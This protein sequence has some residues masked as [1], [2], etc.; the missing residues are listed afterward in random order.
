[1]AGPGQIVAR[2]KGYL[3]SLGVMTNGQLMV[4]QTGGIPLPKTISGDLT[5]DAN[6]VAVVTGAV[7]ERVAAGAA[8]AKTIAS[9]AIAL[10]AGK[11]YYT[12]AGEGAAADNLDVITGGTVGDLIFLRAVSDSVTITLRD[13]AVA[14]GSG[15][16]ITPAAASFAFAEDDDF[17]ILVCLGTDWVVLPPKTLAADVVTARIADAAVT[18]AKLAD[19]VADK[20][21]TVVC[22]P[23]AAVG[24]VITVSV[25][26]NDIQGNALAAATQ[27]VFKLVTAADASYS[28]ADGGAGTG[29]TTSAD[30]VSAILTSAAGLAEIAITDTAAETIAIAFETPL[31]PVVCPL[32]Y[33]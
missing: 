31:G 29:L 18:A 25:Q 23:A 30:K 13:K 20:L 33:A 24:D 19:V 28:P 17:A 26:V 15:N 6:G 3:K 21:W 5:I 10:T 11:M 9:G 12:L 8:T 4:G 22:T 16:L 14:G 1:M 7:A 27:L 2:V 32:T